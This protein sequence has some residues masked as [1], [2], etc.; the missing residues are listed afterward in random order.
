MPSH[1]DP[2]FPMSDSMHPELRA[3]LIDL[4][5]DTQEI[6]LALRGDNFGQ[7]GIV[8]NLANLKTAFEEHVIENQISFEQE[9][10][11]CGKLNIKIVYGGGVIA[12]V[13]F[14]L[15]LYKIFN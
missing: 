6:K 9:N 10:K 12:G 3:F 7:P 2:P 14:A 8:K 11:E 4:R 15:E 5:S 1:T 13:L